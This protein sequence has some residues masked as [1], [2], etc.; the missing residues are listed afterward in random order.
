MTE[1]RR[2][3]GE[4]RALENGR[5]QSRPEEPSTRSVALQILAL[6]P[7]CSPAAQP[8]LFQRAG[9]IAIKTSWS[10]ELQVPKA[11]LRFPANSVPFLIRTTK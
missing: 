1:T 10:T 4:R 11:L 8:T 9:E 6:W 7:P 3:V 5:E 2:K